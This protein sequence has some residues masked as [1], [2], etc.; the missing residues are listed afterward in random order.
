MSAPVSAEAVT[1]ALI[2]QAFPAL[3]AAWKSTGTLLPR[4]ADEKLMETWASIGAFLWAYAGHGA[5]D[6][7]DFDPATQRFGCSCGTE[8][9]PATERTG[10]AA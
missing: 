6:R 7:W 8:L 10:A 4:T 1:A 5:C 9:F 3:I 2:V